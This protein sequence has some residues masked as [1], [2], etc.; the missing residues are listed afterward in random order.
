MLGL[1]AYLQ[2]MCVG[3]VTD[4]RMYEDDCIAT[5]MC[6][7][8]DDPNYACRPCIMLG[9]LVVSVATLIPYGILRRNRAVPQHV[10]SLYVLYALEHTDPNAPRELICNFMRWRRVGTALSTVSMNADGSYAM[11]GRVFAAQQGQHTSSHAHSQPHS[12]QQRQPEGNP[13]AAAGEQITP[14][15]DDTSSAETP[16]PPAAADDTKSPLL[17]DSLV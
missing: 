1:F 7:F 2:I 14:G 3:V 5:P 9:L 16:T 6:G 8:N 17:T 12:L 10:N 4:P 13:A 11:G 15:T